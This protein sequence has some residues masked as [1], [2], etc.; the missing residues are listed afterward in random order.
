MIRIWQILKRISSAKVENKPLI[1][2]E[3]PPAKIEIDKIMAG[4]FKFQ[5]LADHA[6]V[7]F[8][9]EIP[10]DPNLALAAEQGKNFM[11]TFQNSAASQAFECITKK[12]Q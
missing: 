7:P 12:L 3:W 6:S 11:H 8:L 9:G 2:E 1:S 10:I 4:F 5:A